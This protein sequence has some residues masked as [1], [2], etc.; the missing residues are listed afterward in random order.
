MLKIGKQLEIRAKGF[1]QPVTVSEVVGIGGP[2]K[3]SLVQT[4]ESLVALTEEIPVSY[5]IAEA[6]QPQGEMFKGSLTKLSPKRAEVRLESPVAI[7]SDLEMLLTS[8]EGKRIDGS[9]HCKVA[10]T[11]ADSSRRFLVHFT[12]MSP[13]V[14]T[15]IR[16]VVGKAVESKA[17]DGSPMRSAGLVAEH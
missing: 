6:S 4:R 7:F 13:A 2:H 9:L 17:G 3:L 10:S 12:S 14:E 15:F 1:E 5:F 8:T 11:V 16:S